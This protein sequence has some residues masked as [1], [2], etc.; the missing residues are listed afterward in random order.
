MKKTKPVL[1]VAVVQF[2]MQQDK[3]AANLAVMGKFIRRAA[4][5]GADIVSFPEMCL[6]GYNYLFECKPRKLR[7]I[8]EDAERGPSV[9]KVTALAKRYGIVV[10][11]GLLERA[12]DGLFNTYVIVTPDKGMIFKHRKIHAFENSAISQGNRL[13]VFDLFGWKM[14]VLICYDNNLPE[15]PR[16]L[17]LKGAELIFAPHQTGAFDMS[18]RGMGR[19]PLDVWQNRDRDPA[20]LQQAIEGP[21]GYQW[22]AKWLPS[23]PYDNNLFY[24]FA[25]GVGIDGPEVRVGCSMI[26]DPEGLVLAETKRAGDEMIVASLSRDAR[27]RTIAGGH[28]K[29]RRPSLYGKIVEPVDERD[30]RSVRNELTGHKIK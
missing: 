9:R 11:F 8:A 25:N 13:E 5:E 27:V 28:L 24:L 18:S 12:A 7:A 22:I 23:R 10:A 21:K 1:K 20:A 14:G 16:V 29:V 17:C 3:K 19:I 15:N 26:L 6:N 4:E 2:E 30:T